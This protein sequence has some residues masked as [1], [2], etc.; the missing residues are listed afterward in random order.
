MSIV[1]LK[2]KTE[3]QYSK[4][5][6]VGPYFALNGIQR[7]IGPGPVDLARK[8]TSTPFKGPLP[9]GHGGGARCRV[10]G[11]RGRATKCDGGGGYPVHVYHGASC[12]PQT[13]VK[14]STMNTSGLIATKYMGLLHGT[15]PRSVVQVTATPDSSEVTEAAALAVYLCPKT[16]PKECSTPCTVFAKPIPPIDFDQYIEQSKA[17]QLCKI[18][19]F[20][21][22]VNNSF[23]AKKFNVAPLYNSP[24][25][26]E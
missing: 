12:T 7:F 20:P 26:Y 24:T 4:M 2:R 22:R 3:S 15:Y 25:T 5:H 10:R 18:P 6:T 16:P 14:R 17:G 23:C 19:H 21:F 13:L 1:A 8:S 9:K 11:I